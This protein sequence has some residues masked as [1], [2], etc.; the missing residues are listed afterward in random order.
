MC[1]MYISA[2]LT[3]NETHYITKAFLGKGSIF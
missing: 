2:A 1:T 3:M